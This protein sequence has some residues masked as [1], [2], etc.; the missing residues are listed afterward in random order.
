V[1]AHDTGGDAVVL[2]DAT[3]AAAGQQ[4][5]SGRLRFSG[6]GWKTT[7]TAASQ[8]VDLIMELRSVQGTANPSSLFAIA[9]QINSG[10]YTDRLTL[11]NLG[12]F[13]VTGTITGTVITGTQIVLNGNTAITNAGTNNFFLGGSGNATLTGTANFGLGAGALGVIAAGINNF[14]MGV[15]ALGQ[16]A[17]GSDNVGIGTLALYNLLS[18]SNNVAIGYAAL[19][20]T[21]G[22]SNVG[23]GY[24][25]GQ[26]ETGSNAF[27]V[28]NQSYA[29]TAL[30]KAGSLLY[31]VFNATPASQTL[32]V[33]AA[34][35]VAQTVTSTAYSV[36]V[37]QVIGARVTGYA[38][39]TGTPNKA[40]AYATSTVTLAQLAG[41]MMQL[42]ADL[43]A[44][45]LIG[46]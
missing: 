24:C 12:N 31:G 5:Y 18:T 11:D 13:A 20:N 23:I 9:T 26:R 3:A 22:S 29:N 19:S 14:G 33:N 6:Q 15:L 32:T 25:A 8:Q 27:Y 30:E 35:T 39:M 28:G 38:A 46:A 10:G 42:Q 1:L 44:H 45:G 4:Q 21:A 7:A 36:G 2:L 16:N 17:S 40:T 41:R 43:T 37:N 34:L